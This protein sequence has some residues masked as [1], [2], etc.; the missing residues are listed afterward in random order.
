M[1]DITIRE[2]YTPGVIGGL[3]TLH[4]TYDG[5]RWDLGPTFEAEIA[6]GLAEFV[7]R[8]DP[9]I[10]GL[11]TVSAGDETVNGG[12]VIDSRRADTD[13][14]QLRYFVLD[15]ALHGRGLG[16]ELIERAMAFCRRHDYDRVFLWTVDE[17][18]AAIHLYESVGFEATDEIDLH[19]GWRTDVPYRLFEYDRSA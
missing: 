14:A 11:W 7:A 10:D 8:Y 4:A 12:I 15:P 13:G 9:D 17:L 1:T 5:T 19:T 2:E 6:D 16:R 3:T 18:A